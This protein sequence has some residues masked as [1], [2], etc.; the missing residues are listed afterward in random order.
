MYRCVHT[1]S[2]EE[3]E[4]E[5]LTNMAGAGHESELPTHL[6][7]IIRLSFF[8]SFTSSSTNIFLLPYLQRV[9]IKQNFVAP[10]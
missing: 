7:Y 3:V 1:L 6:C 4:S 2:E 5:S 9:L 8:F 10:G